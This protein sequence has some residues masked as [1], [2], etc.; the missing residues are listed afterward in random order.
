MFLSFTIFYFASILL[1]DIAKTFNTP[2]GTFSQLGL[3]VQ[4]IGLFL[5]LAMGAIAIRFRLKSLYLFGAII[6]GVGA[7][8]FFF[9]PNIETVTLAYFLFGVGGSTLGIMVM[10]L[11][12]TLFP[13]KKR[14]WAIG[15][16]VSTVMF[17]GVAVSFVSGGIAQ[18]AGW[19]SVLLWFVFPISILCVIL[20][21]VAIPSQPS[22]AQPQRS[23]YHTAFKQ[24][25][26]NRSAM[27]C[28]LA[29]ATRV[30][31][32]VVALY[33]VSF[34]RLDFHV[35][36]ATGGLIAS[37][38]GIGGVFGAVVGGRS[39]N[40]F[41]RKPVAAIWV[42]VSGI[43]CVMFTFIPNLV[44]S[45]AVLALAATTVGVM[46]ASLES[47]VIE[48][49]P[50][51]RASMM[52]VN[53]TFESLGMIAGII[54]AGFVLNFYHNNFQLLMTILG[55]VGGSSALFILLAKDPCRVAPATQLKQSSDNDSK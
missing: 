17:A 31:I 14:P 5:G 49:V 47:L 52:S 43:S 10:S 46:V 34:Y 21:L 45:V 3:I 4:F 30:F 11:I 40:R 22:A 9:A 50:S 26:F 1:V 12:G 54:I 2:I 32:A 25:L 36:V 15:L 19:R 18:F 44:L 41:G 33:A 8:L 38:C 51:F 27:A 6:Y 37:A 53:S 13:L 28:V 35:S 24:I 42:L 55:A 39:V 16:A 23:V 29:N 20:G 7:L 48:Q